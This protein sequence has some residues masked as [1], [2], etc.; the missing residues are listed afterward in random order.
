MHERVIART[1]GEMEELVVHST[2]TTT[3]NEPLT[4]S[5]LISNSDEGEPNQDVAH[6][7][8]QEDLVHP[9]PP[10]GTL[11]YPLAQPTSDTGGGESRVSTI[12]CSS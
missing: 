6:L 8:I 12:V 10:S 11:D 3:T 5:E 1:Q 7:H 4:A 9:E 2:G